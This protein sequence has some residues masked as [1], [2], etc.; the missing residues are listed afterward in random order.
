M[1]NEASKKKILVTRNNYKST[2]LLWRGRRIN[3]L[4]SQLP[5]NQAKFRNTFFSSIQFI[6]II[7][8][9][10]FVRKSD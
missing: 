6:F 5:A 7:Y 8:G 4:F 1:C 2:K 10:I 9:I 3:K